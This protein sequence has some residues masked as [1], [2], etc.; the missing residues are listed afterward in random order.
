MID[1]H[2]HTIFSDGSLL[3]SELVRRAS[4]CGYEV[5]ALTDHVDSSNIDFVLPRL[6]KVSKDLNRFWGKKIKV[7]PGVEITH[8]PLELIPR[9]IKY[10]RR[11]GKVLVVVHGE[12]PVEPVIEGTNKVAVEAGADILAHPGKITDE[13]ALMASKTGV[14]LELTARSGHLEGNRH[15]YGVAKRNGARLVFNSD[16]HDMDDLLNDIQIKTILEESLDLTIQEIEQILQ[17][18]CQLVKKFI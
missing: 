13:V 6:I 4:V 11:K 5:I 7:I 10:A 16:A 15:V 3:P 18:S 17:N 2:T 8:A 14:C 9:L 12:S 1:L